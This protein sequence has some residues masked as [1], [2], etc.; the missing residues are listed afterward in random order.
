M[1]QKKIQRYRQRQRQ[2]QRQLQLQRQ[3]EEDEDNA[4]N[5]RIQLLRAQVSFLS[6]LGGGGLMQ[7]VAYGEMTQMERER[8]KRPKKR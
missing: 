1:N 8:E 4:W 7:M 5:R 2:K 6:A 3:K